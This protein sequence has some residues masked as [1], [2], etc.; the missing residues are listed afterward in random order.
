MKKV[1]T[2]DRPDWDVKITNTTNQWNN[3]TICGPLARQ[4]LEKLSTDIDIDKL[5]LTRSTTKLVSGTIL[6]VFGAVQLFPLLRGF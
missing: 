6:I 2:F 1:L 3:A 5:P 4:L